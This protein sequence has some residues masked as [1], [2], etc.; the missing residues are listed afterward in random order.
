TYVDVLISDIGMPGADGYDLITR[1]RDLERDHGGRI[2][3]VALTAYAGEEDR[4]RALAAGFS[5]HV[6]KPVS[7]TNLVRLVAQTI[8][9]PAL[10]CSRLTAGPT[11]S[12]VGPSWPPDAPSRAGSVTRSARSWPHAR[13]RRR[14]SRPC[15]R[16]RRAARARSTNGRRRT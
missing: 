4:D 8:G 3:A 15:P 11:S 5:A 1:L 14:S 2:P 16:R 6:T 13:R 12:N 7:P 10:A 9:R